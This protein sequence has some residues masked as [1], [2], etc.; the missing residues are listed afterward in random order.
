MWH[1]RTSLVNVWDNRRTPRRM[2]KKARLL[3][4]P[5][6]AATSPARPESAKTASRPRTRLVPSKAAASEGARRT[7]RYVEPLS[8]ARTKLADFFSILL[9]QRRE[10]GLFRIGQS[11]ILEMSK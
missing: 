2:L 4:R 6:L 3:T 8:E 5:T 1:T 10:I 11:S 9:E 7:L